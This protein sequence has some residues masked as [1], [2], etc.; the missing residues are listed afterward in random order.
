MDKRLKKHSTIL[1]YLILANFIAQIPYTIHLYGLPRLVA[2]TPGWLAMLVVFVLFVGG[3]VLLMRRNKLGYLLLL[4]FLLMEFIFYLFN[5]I[6][7][8]IHGY[9]ITYH[10]MHDDLLLKIV[11]LIGF[12]NLF[13]SGYFLF[14]LVY[15]RETFL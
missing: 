12:I 5:E 8:L 1:F 2:V 14:L 10:V 4:I 15:K 9:G 3:Y 7:G 13:A 11:F 6:S